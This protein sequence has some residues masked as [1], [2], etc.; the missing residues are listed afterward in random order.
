MIDKEIANKIF[1]KW[2]NCK[3]FNCKNIPTDSY[4]CAIKCLNCIRKPENE[5]QSEIHEE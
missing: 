4:I 1:I 2:S 3:I 5:D